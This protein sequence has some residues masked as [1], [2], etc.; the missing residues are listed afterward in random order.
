[1][2]IRSVIV[3]LVQ[4]RGTRGDI[5]ARPGAFGCGEGI[6]I[7]GGI[8]GGQQRRAAVV[9]EFAPVAV[10]QRAFDGV[11]QVQA[12]SEAGALDLEEGIDRADLAQVIQAAQAD[13][14]QPGRGLGADVSD[15]FIAAHA[16]FSRVSS[17]AAAIASRPRC[18][19]SS[20]RFVIG[21][22][23][24]NTP[25]SSSPRYSGTTSSERDA[26]SQGI[27]PGKASTSATRCV[28][29]LTAAVPQTPRPSAMR[30]QAGWPWNGPT[31]SSWPS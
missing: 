28:S 14:A 4:R 27:W 20:N 11:E 13:L 3:V 16:A 10:L 23:R 25:I 21:L 1:M 15:L 24:S 17:Q 8:H 2:T 12:G 5:A 7:F 9:V 31:T 30:M 26:E 6:R 29:R 18:S 19:S 22:S